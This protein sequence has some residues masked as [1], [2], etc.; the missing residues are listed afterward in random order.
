MT[1]VAVMAAAHSPTTFATSAG[2]GLGRDE[3]GGADGGESGRSENRLR[4]MGFL[5]VLWGCACTSWQ[6][7]GRTVRAV[8]RRSDVSAIRPSRY[9]RARTR[10][11][12]GPLPRYWSGRLAALRHARYKPPQSQLPRLFP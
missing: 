7:V 11:E 2:G 9:R 3:R 12:A 4:I 6:S 1:A 8:Q 10:A 5:L